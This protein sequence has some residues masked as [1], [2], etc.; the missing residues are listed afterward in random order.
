MCLPDRTRLRHIHKCAYLYDL[1]ARLVTTTRRYAYRLA[2][3][4]RLGS[5]PIYRL[6]GAQKTIWPAVAIPTTPTLQDWGIRLQL[7][8]G[9]DGKQPRVY[10][11][12]R[13]GG[14]RPWVG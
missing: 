13:E 3:R 2:R 5:R 10:A 12:V 11:H 8:V 1:H 14:G 4:E 7:R 6:L 9:R